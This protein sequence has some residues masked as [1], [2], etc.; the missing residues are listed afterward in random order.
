[1]WSG[2]WSVA[3][4]RIRFWTWIWFA[5]TVDWD[6][7]WLVDFSARKIPLVPLFFDWSTNNGATDLKMDGPFLE[8]KSSFK[9]LGFTF[10]SKLDR[11]SYIISIAKIGSKK[12]GA[13]I[14]SMKF[15]SLEIA[16]YCFK[17]T[18]RPCMEC[19]CHVWACALSCYLKLL[20]KLQKW[21]CRTFGPYLVPLLNPWLIF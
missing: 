6:R 10:S 5:R 12:V 7:K 21:I 11:G 13:L 18:I 14:R 16:L 3:T 4:I 8:E 20:D 1:M 17:S 9:I 15:L 2:I 19:C